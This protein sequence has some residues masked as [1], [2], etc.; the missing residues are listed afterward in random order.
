MHKSI[1]VCVALLAAGAARAQ[2]PQEHSPAVT[3]A[4]FDGTWGVT[5]VCAEY[6]DSG[7]GAKGYTFRFLAQVKDGVLEAQHGKQGEPGS[8]HYRGQIL[9]DGSAEIQGNG[10]TG[11]PDYAVAQ[12]AKST[13]YAYRLKAKFE[14][15]RGSATRLDL[16]QCEATFVKQ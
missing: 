8:L 10:F 14:G 12:V 5:L 11:N 6:K 4:K 9:A 2:L 1:L 15:N 3:S 13:P 7:A 16:R